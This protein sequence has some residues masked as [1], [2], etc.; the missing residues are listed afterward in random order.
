[1]TQSSVINITTLPPPQVIQTVDYEALVTLM[2]DDLVARFPAITGVIDLESEPA[3]KLIE[4]FA[5]REMQLR[6]RVNDAA[7]ANLLAF[8][9]NSDLDHLATFYDVVRMD[10]ETDARLRERVV[11]AIRGRSTGG[12][13]PRYRY[14]AR[15]ADIRVADAVVWREGTS[16]LVRCAVF[17]TD[18]NGVPDAA[19]LQT[20]TDALTAPDVR[21]VN[22]T[23]LVT[24]AVQKVQNIGAKLTLLPETSSS[25]VADLEASLRADWLA[26]RGL[27]FDLTRSWITAK[28]MRGGIYS[29]E[30][31]EPAANVI[32]QPSEAIA[33]GTVTL[34]IEG[35]DF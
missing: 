10:G 27:G 29:V 6:A 12:T 17:S 3:R 20:V 28:L 7:R 35:R 15:S 21:M 19:L 25:I 9:I 2:R 32:A 1:M 34:T 13:E 22:D 16:P 26:E 5:Y 8:A 31:I 18:N 33:I 4:V 23:I 11:L 14:V 24:A 30:V